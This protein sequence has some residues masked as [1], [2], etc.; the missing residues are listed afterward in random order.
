MK[1]K[2][3]KLALTLMLVLCMAVSVFAVAMA[4]DVDSTTVAWDEYTQDDLTTL[5][6]TIPSKDGYLFGGWYTKESQTH[7]EEVANHL[8]SATI[9]EGANSIYAKFVPKAVM[10][11]RAQLSTE[12]MNQIVATAEDG[13]VDASLRFVTSV[14]SLLYKAVG[15]DVVYV[16]DGET[17]TKNV[18]SNG[19][20]TKLLGADGSGAVTD[21]YVPNQTFSAESEYFKACTVEKIGVDYCDV[22]MSV[23]PYW[24]TMDGTKVCGD[25]VDKNV[26]SG[27][28]RLSNVYVSATGTDGINTGAETSPV[29]TLSHAM[30]RTGATANIIV[31]DSIEANTM[32]TI[33]GGKNI[34]V[35]NGEGADVTIYRGSG[36]STSNLFYVN[37]DSQLTIEGVEN[38]DGGE[39]VLDGRTKDEATANKTVAEMAGST[40]AL[41][42][43]DGDVYL[44]NIVA[45][46]CK[47]T[48]GNAGVLRTVT[49]CGS[50]VH[51]TDSSFRN[52]YSES[53]GGVFY[54]DSDS[55]DVVINNCD[56][57]NNSAK[58]HGGA[59][60]AYEKKVTIIDCRFEGNTAG[61]GGAIYEGGT[62]SN[63]YL[64]KSSSSANAYFENNSSTSDYGGAIGLGNGGLS[65]DGYTFELNESK[66]GGGAIYM[67]GTSSS[68]LRSIKNS[69]FTDNSAIGQGG[70]VYAAN[71]DQTINIEDCDFES[72]ESTGTNG[73]A[74][75]THTSVMNIKNCDFTSNASVGRGGA[76]YS[77]TNNTQVNITSDKGSKF[78]NNT[79]SAANSSGENKGGAICFGNTTAT[80]KIEGYTFKNNG[81]NSEG[82]VKSKQ[83]GAIT[84]WSKATITDCEF[85]SNASTQYSGAIQVESSTPGVTI[86]NTTFTNNVTGQAG[87]AMVTFGTT[88]A[89]GCT[90]TGNNNSGYASNGGGAIWNSNALTLNQCVFTGNSAS[91]SGGGA[92]WV[93]AGTV[94][95]NGGT[96][97]QNTAKTGG[98]V[99]VKAGTLNVNAGTYENNSATEGGAIYQAA[100]TLNINQETTVKTVFNQNTA[101]GWGGAIRTEDSTF[102]ANLCEF[103]NNSAKYGGAI[104]MSSSSTVSNSTFT[105]NTATTNE[106]G[107]CYVDKDSTFENCSFDGNKAKTNGWALS[108]GANVTLKGTGSFANNTKTD[109]STVTGDAGAIFLWQNNKTFQ[110][111]TEA[112]YTYTFGQNEFYDI[113][114]KSGKTHDL[115]LEGSYTSN[116][117]AE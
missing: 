27:M 74:I 2:V 70:A 80:V 4:A 103:K 110:G 52:N 95:I 91:G 76:I 37:N 67:I 117:T 50:I 30:Y 85:D 33:Q 40:I 86:T 31:K 96:N 48:S 42:I 36:L 7:D 34:T 47:N 43:A 104:L 45:Q 114:I 61:T 90:F 62:D 19:V 73:G 46:Y 71:K 1:T 35:K 26:S 102:N 23:T 29:A 107:A 18:E 75:G 116:D 100:G 12:D 83:G 98:A 58:S 44:D 87:G 17:Q 101:T 25:T 65:V 79:I 51:V 59:I 20:Y 60:G 113:F 63:I 112:A 94:K 22:L 105:S 78:E 108:V 54:V 81:K 56:F 5:G 69:N 16:K 82:V 89:T 72:N 15:F 14:D 68:D 99:H 24:V 109:D 84:T 39:F 55:Q 6:E 13:N 53:Y 106:G 111:D 77:G 38:A 66:T 32:T 64:S 93:N 115:S 57:N 97:S 41:I 92:I 3:S 9:P 49:S 21:E 88:T 8:T 10:G 11:V 28:T